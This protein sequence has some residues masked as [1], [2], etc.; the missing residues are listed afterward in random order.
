[1]PMKSACITNPDVRCDGGS[2]SA[3]NARNG[4]IEMLIDASRIHSSDAAIQS[5]VDVGMMNSAIDAR[6]APVRKY[7]RRLPSG[8][9]VRSLSA[10]T[11]GCTT[12][13]VTGAASQSSGTS[14]GR[15]PR[16]S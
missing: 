12:R 8:P 10:P 7:G 14:S 2:L 13:P 3:T 11:I 4:S 15:A 16:R 6:M 9:H 1:M 5:E